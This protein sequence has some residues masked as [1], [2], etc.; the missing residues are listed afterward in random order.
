[1]HTYNMHLHSIYLDLPYNCFVTIGPR[2]SAV[3]TY[4]STNSSKNKAAMAH[5][6]HH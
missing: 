5:Y 6:N 1:M 4:I 3:F 2:I